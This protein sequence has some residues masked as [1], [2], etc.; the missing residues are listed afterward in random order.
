MGWIYQ[1]KENQIRAELVDKR[2]VIILY[3][4]GSDQSKQIGLEQEDQT[5]QSR[6]DESKNSRE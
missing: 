4:I 1:S 2:E 5:K 3:W 6:E